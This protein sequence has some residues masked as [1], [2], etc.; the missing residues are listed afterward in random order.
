M[1]ILIK[2]SYIFF[3]FFVA[4]L[5]VGVLPSLAERETDKLANERYSDI[6]G[7]FTI[8]PPAGWR[9][10]DYPQEE[11]GKIAFLGPESAELRILINSV[12]YDLEAF[13]SWCKD[14]EERLETPMNIE[15]T[16]FGGRPS[17]RRTYEI[18]GNKFYA[19]NFFIKNANHNVQYGAPPAKY[20]KFLPIVL[21]SMETYEPILRDLSSGDVKNLYIAKKVRIAQLM[22]DMQNYKM[23]LKYVK[24]GL[25]VSPEHAELLEL[26]H[27]IETKLDK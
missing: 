27:K 14:L 9:I 22:I 7:F 17:I 6:K 25:E 1:R 2:N 18:Q 12:D 10:Q 24:E 11:R 16:T 5:L 23:A 4:V 19:I 13:I 21:K 15:R 3:M 20:E 8:I 26:K